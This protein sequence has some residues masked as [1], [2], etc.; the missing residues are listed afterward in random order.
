MGTRRWLLP[1]A[2]LLVALL[3]ACG[4]GNGRRS[5][6]MPPVAIVQ[7]TLAPL[8]PATA[9]TNTFV[10]HLLDHTT[11]ATTAV[12]GLYE[13]NGAGVAI[14]DLDGDGKLDLVLANLGAPHTIL[15][16]EGEL[17]FR[18][19]RLGDGDGR[20]VNVV[21]VDGDSRLDIVFTQRLAK[22][23]YWRNQGESALARFVAGML[24]GVN[25]PFYSMNWADLDRDGDLD[26][27][28]ASYDTELRKQLGAIFTYQGDG[29]GVFVYTQAEGTFT[30]ERL[31]KQADALAIALPDLNGDSWPDLLVGNDFIRRDAT[32]LS[33]DEGWSAAEPFRTT[34][35]NT[36]S[37]DVSDVDNDG[38]PE[39][40]A[41]DMKPVNQTVE[42][43]AAWL[44][45]MDKMTRPASSADPQIVE[46]VLL[47]RQGSGRFVNQGYQRFV[48]ATG[49]SW[50]S[51]F[52]DL[53]NDGFL[54]LY[55][56]NGMIAEEL[57]H[58]LPNNELVEANMALH[59][60]GQ[61]YFTPA[62]QWGLG[63]TAS[64]RGMSMAD[65]DNDG[66]LDIVVN[67]LQ[68]PAQLFENQLC[69]GASVEIDLRWPASKNPY[70]LGAR[71]V[72]QTTTGRYYRD[73]RAASGYL[74]GD[75]T[76][77][78]IGLPADAQPQRLEIYWPDGAIS[79]IDELAT[80]TLVTVQRSE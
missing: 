55:V 1:V 72:L 12:V 69:G 33:T 17:R 20:A 46:N 6:S 35:E 50:S 22:P 73:I 16:N 56:V 71:L 21:D 39:I 18:T 28:A 15:W 13:S 49:W 52:G 36:M 9:C 64:G 45:M 62:P 31:A 47:V 3:V 61:G 43:L 70:A 48:D 34:S 32:W 30:D 65:L 29:V 40:F 26:L 80:H 8:V 60:D 4:Q 19:E 23:T 44:P 42:T 10:T 24:P 59:N 11:V 7:T 14:N 53:D 74:S 77:I 25:N 58:H 2:L 75:P 66:D 67:N 27:V 57:F 63:S 5:A 51:K 38:S 37:F 41:T 54:D 79:A 78:H 76:R 68:T